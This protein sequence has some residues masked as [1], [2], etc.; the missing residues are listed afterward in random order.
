MTELSVLNLGAGRQS[1]ALLAMASEGFIGPPDVVIHADTGDERKATYTYVDEV[2]RPRCDEHGVVRRG[3][4]DANRDR[5]VVPA[6]TGIDVDD[7]GVEGE[8]ES[9]QRGDG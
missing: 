6:S 7:V 9:D 3:V 4:G 2:V 1:T 8:S 5:C